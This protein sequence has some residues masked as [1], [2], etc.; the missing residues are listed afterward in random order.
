MMM[1]ITGIF[2]VL[3]LVLS[4]C[5]TLENANYYSD[6][7][8]YDYEVTHNFNT[9]A[10]LNNENVAMPDEA[11]VYYDESE[12]RAINPTYEDRLA[13]LEE[14]EAAWENANNGQNSNWEQPRSP[15]YPTIGLGVG[16]AGGGYMAYPMNNPGFI[17]PYNTYNPYYQPYGTQ[18]NTHYG[19]GTFYTPAQRPNSVVSNQPDQSTQPYRPN[20]SS[21]R[22]EAERQNRV[23]QPIRPTTSTTTTT[24]T[25]KPGYNSNSSRQ[26]RTGSG[27]GRGVWSSPGYYNGSRSGSSSGSSRPSTVQGVRRR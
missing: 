10:I 12:A 14:D 11:V 4:S 6:D 27:T 16:I 5:S 25:K 13:A 18:P 9:S 24:T 2:G 15:Y 17:S 8:Y 7:L 23:V 22:Y 19:A 1:K 21:S 26:Y 3:V 20:I